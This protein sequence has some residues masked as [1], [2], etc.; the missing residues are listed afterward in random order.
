MHAL[1]RS[2]DHKE[3]GEVNARYVTK[4][5]GTVANDL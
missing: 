2:H 3:I 5:I 1:G 4:A